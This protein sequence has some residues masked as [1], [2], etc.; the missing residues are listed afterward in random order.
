VAERQTTSAGEKS[1]GM[2]PWIGWGVSTLLLMLFNRGKNRG[3]TTTQKASRFTSDNTNSI[4]SPIPV[5]LGRVMIKN[6]IISYYGAFRADPYTEEYGM[7]SKINVKDILIP[8]LITII[9][10]L[11]TPNKVFTPAGPGT[12]TTQGAKNKMIM[13][14]VYNALLTLLML[15][16]AKHLGRTTIQKGFKYYLGWQHI[17]CWTG[18]NIGVKKLWMNVYDSNVEDSTEKGVWDNNNKIAWEAEN[19]QGLAAYINDDGMFG[20]VDEGGG[21][22]G[23]V[24]YYFGN[25]SQPKDS[26]M[27]DQMRVSTIPTDLQG[28]TPKY[29]M[30]LT[31]VVSNKDK[32]TG[33]YIGKQATIPEMWFEVVNYPDKLSKK[34]KDKK[35]DPMIGQDANPAE[36]I[37]EILTNNYWG[38][39]YNSED[40]VIDEESLVELG[41]TCQKEGL[42]ISC[43]I[44]SVSKAGDYINNILAHISAVKFDDP[45][46]GKLTFKLIR[47]DYDVDKIKKFDTSNCESMEFSRLDW[48]E[49]TSAIALTF[50]DAE[51]KYDNGTI[52]VNDLSNKLITHRYQ[53]ST[54]DGSY[55]TTRDNARYMAQTQLLSAGYPLSSVNFKCN[56]S[57]YDLTIGEPIRIT[58]EPYGINRQVYRV[59]DVDYGSLTEGTIT[60]TAV[61]DVF[62]FEYTDYKYADIPDWTEPEKV[63]EDIKNFLFMEM[64][65][66][67][68]YSLDT[69]ISAWAS[70]P[71]QYTNTWHVWR[72]NEGRY[73]KTVNTSNWSMVARMVA[74]TEEVYGIEKTIEIK[75]IGLDTDR[76][77]DDKLNTIN[78]DK[79]SINN[80]SGMNLLVSDGEI[81]SYDSIEKLPNGNYLLKN[82]I[83]GIF[84]T[85]PK[86]H[87]SS[88]Y[89][90][91]FDIKQDVNKGLPVARNGGTSKESLEITTGTPDKEQT[92]D[93]NKTYDMLTARRAECPS[94]M[95]NLQFS[96]DKGNKSEFKYNFPAGTIF[97]CGIIF[98][99]KTR[100]K[101]NDYNIRSHLEDSV[102]PSESVVNIV[103]VSC[104]GREFEL[105]YPA[106]NEEFKFKWEDFCAKMRNRIM[107][108]NQ[109]HIEILTLDKGKGLYSYDKYEK[110]VI[111]NVPRIVGVVKD[112]SEVQEY[113]ESI[114]KETNIFV[115]DTTVSVQQTMTFDDGALVLVGKEGGTKNQ[116]KG[117]DG[118]IYD[119][120][121]YEAYRIDGVDID[122]STTPPIYT[123]K[124]HKIVLE[125]E[126]IFRTNFNEFANNR[127]EYYRVRSGDIIPYDLYVKP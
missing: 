47:N 74:G 105:E 23:E 14:A 97:T 91:F 30:Y 35:L 126:F 60:V 89:C 99:V 8:L 12:E 2:S 98:R 72:H 34:Y 62:G 4:G 100:N 20:G 73:D 87:Y 54:V 33:A 18:D 24:R 106:Q 124:Y 55:F 94:I 83:R 41:L 107:E 29:P 118:K 36:V 95:G 63:P 111:L 53:E 13:M 10:I 27:E 116:V 3:S 113:I 70:K 5:A 92:F 114:T 51:N 88:S 57:A 93:K 119:V 7:H 117:Q 90:Y 110:D 49:T 32:K 96:A 38:C 17:I 28:L 67:S 48:S 42:G 1:H 50:T 82:V 86:K 104:N 9:A 76:L 26:W 61:E 108:S 31:C 77:F 109:A 127:T 125:E 120:S 69:Y 101:F 39:D 85:I 45:K 22:I 11:I 123:P 112:V 16:F 6:P 19:Q 46:T 40:D 103:R 56:R 66:E 64:P 81:M 84:D 59:T 79:N 21:F 15:L 68:T 44:N 75:S 25:T 58:W 115:P 71:S 122:Y 52:T 80:K 121:G 78:A 43:L 65:Y 37:Y 102:E